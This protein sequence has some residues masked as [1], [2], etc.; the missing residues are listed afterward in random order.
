MQP[1]WVQIAVNPATV[2][3]DCRAKVIGLP[4]CVAAIEPPT[5]IADS[6]ASAP[7]GGA[8]AAGG[9]ACAVDAGAAG[10]VDVPACTRVAGTDDVV[11]GATEALPL[12]PLLDG[13][14]LLD[15]GPLGA[16]VLAAF[17]F[18]PLPHPAK[19]SA[20]MPAIPAPPPSTARRL[21]SA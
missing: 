15:G 11:A 6:L 18:A 19:V 8:G 4:A 2:P 3:D 10:W 12:A 21:I 1:M 5:G 17:D 7:A 16:S 13:V 9:T 14:P 20:A